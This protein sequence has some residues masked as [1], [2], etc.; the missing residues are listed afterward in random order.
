MAGALL[1]C[2]LSFVVLG[3]VLA[4]YIG[5][6]NVRTALR[7]ASI[8]AILGVIWYVYGGNAAFIASVLAL[9]VLIASLVL[10]SVRARYRRINLIEPRPPSQHDFV[11]WCRKRLKNAGWNIEPRPRG[12]T[13]FLVSRD[14]HKYHIICRP[15]MYDFNHILVRELRMTV[16]S[17]SKPTVAVFFSDVPRKMAE[18]LDAMRVVCITHTELEKLHTIKMPPKRRIEVVEL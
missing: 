11:Q 16:A 18:A 14:E 4:T 13:D 6:L 9:V 17:S 8:A 2:Q 10:I 7:D 1:F 3:F 15:T 12:P 5:G